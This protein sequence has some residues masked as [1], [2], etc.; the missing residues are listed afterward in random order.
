MPEAVSALTDIITE[1]LMDS[2]LASECLT[3]T[4][5]VEMIESLR[6]AGMD[7]SKSART[8]FMTLMRRAPPSFDVF[9]STVKEFQG[10]DQL[11]S[12][13]T[14]SCGHVTEQES[15]A[16][17]QRFFQHTSTSAECAS[18]IPR[19]KKSKLGLK[20]PRTLMKPYGFYGIHHVCRIPRSKKFSQVRLASKKTLL[21][22][23]SYC[24]HKR[25]VRE[26]VSRIARLKRLYR[27]GISGEAIRTGAASLNRVFV[28]V[29]KAFREEF[30]PYR[31]SVKRFIRDVTEARVKF[32][33]L[34]CMPVSM[35]QRQKK[36]KPRRR[37]KVRKGERLIEI[38][39]QCVPRIYLPNTNKKGFLKEKKSL[40]RAIPSLLGHKKIEIHPGSCD[41]YLTLRG[42]D[43]LRFVSDLQNSRVLI[44]FIQLD[45]DT[46]I[47][48]GK[49]QSIKVTRLFKLSPLLQPV[50][51]YL[52]DIRQF[53]C[54]AT[55]KDRK[56]FARLSSVYSSLDVTG[57]KYGLKA[58]Q[59]TLEGA[60]KITGFMS[61]SACFACRD[62]KGAVQ[63]RFRFP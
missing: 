43:L 18:R 19:P 7:K 50:A 6:S 60:M 34:E 12:L 31:S 4:K 8:L 40:L 46:E 2:L 57:L 47:Q 27:V 22:S 1:G 45:T 61:T 3:H 35:P 51:E 24:P 59:T 17:P 13:L 10:G 58:M 38:P 62:C 16:T 26:G 15:L 63:T 14:S 11:W 9:C 25:Y 30:E 23:Y 48:F 54:K 20:S 33:F 36:G 28:H 56:V 55:E 52:S 53:Y 44:A 32:R 39:L 42:I 41:V 49:L 5:F 29:H 37:E 21:Q